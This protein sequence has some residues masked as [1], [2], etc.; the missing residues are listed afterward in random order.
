MGKTYWG[1]LFW[2]MIAFQAL[3]PRSPLAAS[4]RRPATFGL[5][6]VAFFVFAVALRR[7]LRGC[8]RDD[9]HRPARLA[10]RPQSRQGHTPRRLVLRRA[11]R[12]YG[13]IKFTT[14]LAGFAVAIAVAL[15]L[16]RRAPRT[17]AIIASVFAVATVA[18]WL[19]CGQN[20]LNIPAYLLASLE[21]SSGYNNAM[22]LPTPHEPF[23]S[24]LAVA[25]L[26][27]LALAFHL[28]TSKR[29]PLAIAT[30]VLCAAFLFLNWK[31][32][33]VRADGHMIGFFICALLPIT[34]F[35]RLFG[36][37]NRS[38]TYLVLLPAGILAVLG[39]EQALPGMARGI[40][41]QQQDRAWGNIHAFT[42]WQEFRDGLRAKMHDQRVQNDL[43]D[44]RDRIGNATVDVLGFEQ[45]V[46]L[47]NK[48]NYRPR[49]VFQSY[50][51]YNAPLARRN[52]DYYAAPGA[53]STSAQDPDHRQP[54]SLDG[55]TRSS[56]TTSSTPTTTSS[57]RKVGSSGTA[58]P[59]PPPPNASPPAASAPS[60]PHSASPST[61]ANS[62]RS[63]SGSPSISALPPRPYP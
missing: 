38:I 44:V 50:G 40:F 60:P 39:I 57:R 6:C 12:P 51:V 14:L 28:F 17:A 43:H 33:F 32:G 54:P 62:P 18:L 37:A 25:G 29:R 9:R 23:I 15:A 59:T 45:A 21:V 47:F 27:G 35:P 22:S 61:S 2:E 46:A 16:Y 8:P 4:L 56:S 34:A 52:L 41:A 3:R 36:V 11:A 30:A 10:T 49:P 13:A 48:F 63:R 5:Q 55:P 20:P 58:G 7:R 42:H 53:P 19:L 24:G 1:Q 26:L 31:H